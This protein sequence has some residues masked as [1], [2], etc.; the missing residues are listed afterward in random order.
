[1]RSVT[2]PVF[3]AIA[4]LPLLTSLPGNSGHIVHAMQESPGHRILPLPLEGPAT[5]RDQIELLKQFKALLKSAQPAATDSKGQAP[6]EQPS[7]AKR[8]GAADSPSSSLIP[9][10]IG[11]EH[12]QQLQSLMRQLTDRLPQGMVPPSLDQLPP[13]QRA[14]VEQA[15]SDPAMQQ[16]V[17]QLLEQFSRSGV[18]PPD[19]PAG[20]SPKVPLPPRP[21]GSSDSRSGSDNSSGSKQKK[22]V[23]EDEMRSRSDGS[24]G[25]D[26]SNVRGSERPVP[27]K[28]LPKSSLPDNAEKGQTSDGS[29]SDRLPTDAPRNSGSDSAQG[30]QQQAIADLQRLLQQFGGK[31]P[32]TGSKPTSGLSNQMESDVQRPASASSRGDLP[33]PD[34]MLDNISDRAPLKSAE[35][36]SRPENGSQPGG[37]RGDVR[38]TRQKQISGQSKSENGQRANQASPA[39]DG[40]PPIPPLDIRSELE[41]RGF[42]GALQKI[43]EK[44]KAE[45]RQSKDQSSESSES[46][47]LAAGTE[48]PQSDGLED[49]VIRLLDG[50]R[51]DVTDR[52]QKKEPTVPEVMNFSRGTRSEL[53]QSGLT[54]QGILPPGAAPGRSQSTVGGGLPGGGL[55]GAGL[56]GG[57]SFGGAP[58]AN[59]PPAAQQIG[60]ST[61][62]RTTAS[63]T[64]AELGKAASNLLAGLAKAPEPAGADSG[65]TKSGTSL[66]SNPVSGNWEGGPE[67]MSGLIL[68]GG[69][70]VAILAATVLGLFLARR[71]TFWQR[72]VSTVRT[73]SIHRVSGV[74]SRADIV[75]GFHQLVATKSDETAAWRTHRA[76][77][78]DMAKLVPELQPAINS[79]ADVYEH[80]RYLPPDIELTTEQYRMARS[81]LER[82][83]SCPA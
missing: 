68:A 71:A 59:S 39:K 72:I 42:G 61:P 48:Q 32:G 36:P 81:A 64:M 44:A 45:A 41:R 49:S 27:S 67:S 63:S 30:S 26:G 23:A 25:N 11:P 34:S 37:D 14:Q 1:M 5:T 56:P 78:E 80:A 33:S 57:V 46:G 65:G 82:C 50:I 47:D 2:S 31:D 40:Q 12:V 15:L 10:G 16:K 62:G 69:I 70:M 74:N 76:A 22:S 43:V 38:N 21:G 7:D 79:L 58:S 51:R 53:P 29:P 6:T 9:P 35:Q 60:A 54:S 24:N 4:I 13:E 52:T 3:V 77:A 19:N 28:G 18:L 66:F 75:R 83:E 8:E 20:P 55:P 17:R 73:D